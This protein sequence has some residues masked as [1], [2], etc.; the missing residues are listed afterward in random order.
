M[1]LMLPFGISRRALLST[2]A[3][4]AAL[5]S[6]LLFTAAQAQTDPLPSW[7]DGPASGGWAA[8]EQ[9]VA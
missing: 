9:D 2:L 4:L 5:P 7:T 1:K 8:Q 3:A 6:P